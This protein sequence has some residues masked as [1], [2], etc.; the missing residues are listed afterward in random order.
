MF[1]TVA[2][3]ETATGFGFV[4]DTG[5]PITAA[6]ALAM[7]VSN[8]ANF[9]LRSGA[10]TSAAGLAVDTAL[11]KFRIA[12]TTTNITWYVDDVSQ[13]TLALETDEFP[14]S[15]GAGIQAAGANRF[16]LGVGHIWYS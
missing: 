10:A 15:F 2:N 9:V 12:V 8:G 4:E 14:V 16:S 11:H 7:I 3:N 5:S 1:T 13:N 6:D